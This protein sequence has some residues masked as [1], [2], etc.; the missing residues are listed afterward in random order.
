M[1]NI[2]SCLGI[3]FLIWLGL[4][5]LVHVGWLK[6]SY[7]VLEASGIFGFILIFLAGSQD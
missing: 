6:E 7:S 3:V 5:G 1:G 4:N 2:L